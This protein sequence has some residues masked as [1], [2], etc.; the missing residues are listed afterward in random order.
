MSQSE[1][2]SGNDG[3]RPIEQGD[4]PNI[5]D[6]YAVSV[7]M[8][9]QNILKGTKCFIIDGFVT[10][11][12][13]NLPIALNNTFP[14]TPCVPTESVDNSTGAVGDKQIRVML[15]G[16]IVALTNGTTNCTVGQYV[17]ITDTDE[18]SALSQSLVNS[19]RKYARYMGTEAAVF[20][21]D[22]STPFAENLSVGI[23]PD[24]N[25]GVGEVGWFQLVES[26]L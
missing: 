13:T 15:P 4:T 5:L 22:G 11:A 6:D 25:L 24:V 17:A 8:S 16:Q 20:S 2:T 19:I 12:D 7:S 26:A 23:V 10:I 21:R 18:I 3:T 14:L 9:N 1:F